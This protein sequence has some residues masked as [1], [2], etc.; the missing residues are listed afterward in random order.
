MKFHAFCGKSGCKPLQP[1]TT[2]KS[3]LGITAP[4]GAPPRARN[5]PED[6][7]LVQAALN[8]F[9]PQQGGPDPKPK[10]D[11]ICGPKTMAAILKFQPKWNVR[12]PDGVVDVGGPIDKSLGG[13]SSTYSD[14]PA[15]MA[16]HIQQVR[17]Y[18]QIVLS[19]LDAAMRYQSKSE[20]RETDYFGK[21]CWDKLTKHFQVD[22]FGGYSTWQEQLL[23]IRSI[24][25]NMWV[26]IGYVPFGLMLFADE[27]ETY[28]M[29]ALA[30]ATLGGYHVSRRHIK[31]EGV[32]EGTIYL[33]PQMQQAKQDTFTYV[34]IHELAHFVGPNYKNPNSITDFAYQWDSVNYKKLLPWQRVHNADCYAQY[35]LDVM[36]RPFNYDAALF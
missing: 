20:G 1:G 17:N 23:W 3:R 7:R 9:T 33:C 16:G 27:P 19:A 14:L 29:G 13:P 12:A 5:L 34:L 28:H 4:V 25:F 11:G 32:F 35:A 22:K 8:N 6:V 21:I 36:N 30:F 15:E 24:Y 31:T 10:V 26:A 18:I 2:K